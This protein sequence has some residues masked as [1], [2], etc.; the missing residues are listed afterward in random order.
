MSL[1]KII[2]LK[3]PTFML[4][5]AFVLFGGSAAFFYHRAQTNDR[6]LII[7]GLITLEMGSADIFYAVF[8]VL[9]AAMSLSGLYLLIRLQSIKNFRIVIGETTLTLPPPSLWK[10]FNEVS[11]PLD[12]IVSVG[13]NSMALIINES[14][15]RHSIPAQW[16]NKYYPMQEVADLII[17]R[18][19]ELHGQKQGLKEGKSKS[20][21]PKNKSPEE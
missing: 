15:M 5:L 16:F 11:I 18:V 2:P 6:G 20:K 3:R 14:D 9:S 8:C 21:R 13:L 4:L 10:S 19:R 12:R 17:G 7:N 1:E